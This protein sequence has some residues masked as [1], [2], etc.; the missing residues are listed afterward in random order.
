[1]PHYSQ[2]PAP[3]KNKRDYSDR[4]LGGADVIQPGLVMAPWDLFAD[5]AVKLS[6]PETV[7]KLPAYDYLPIE[8]KDFTLDTTRL[9]FGKWVLGWKQFH[10]LELPPDNETQ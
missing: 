5:Y 10:S 2:P 4:L 9:Q 7:E 3:P 6:L 8:G 1:M